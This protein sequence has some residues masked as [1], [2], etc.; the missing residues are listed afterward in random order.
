MAFNIANLALQAHANGKNRFRY[1]TT[2]DTLATILASGYFGK[3]STTGQQSSDMLAAGDIIE[4]SA[5]DGFAVL[6]VD[7]VSGTTVTT[8]FGPGE[9]TWITATIMN[10]NTA[11]NLYV[12]APF[13][14]NIRR[15]K[16]IQQGEITTTSLE[17]VLRIAGTQVTGSR[18][19]FN[20]SGS[21]AGQVYETVATGANAVTEG[22]AV[23]IEWAGGAGAELLSTEADMLVLI[24]FTPA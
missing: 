17:M 19:V 24:E 20:N 15:V 6:R 18:I 21:G 2:A 8:E 23:Q 11:N 16:A 10:A 12:A 13:D 3:D 22:Q 9:S 4:V 14:G 1:D 7:A 5:S